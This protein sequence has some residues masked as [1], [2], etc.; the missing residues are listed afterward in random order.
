[1][2]SVNNTGVSNQVNRWDGYCSICKKS[3]A[4][5]FVQV[6]SRVE[7]GDILAQFWCIDCFVAEA[8]K[9]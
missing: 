4:K 2:M 3:T 7:Y 9:K 6:N 1:M 8:M 5:R